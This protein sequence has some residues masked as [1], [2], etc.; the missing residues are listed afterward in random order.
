MSWDGVEV[1][2]RDHPNCRSALAT[3]FPSMSDEE[4]IRVGERFMREYRL[5]ETGIAFHPC[6]I[7]R[8]VYNGDFK[9]YTNREFEV[10]G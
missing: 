10:R 6:R 4:A 9:P 2:Y 1:H 3:D 8:L 5:V 7:A